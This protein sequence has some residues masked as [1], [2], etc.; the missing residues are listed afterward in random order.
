MMMVAIY[1]KT[2]KPW[3]FGLHQCSYARVWTQEEKRLFQEI[4]RRLSDSLSSFLILHNLKESE[5]RYRLI[6]EN[7]ADTIA[8]YDLNLNPTY[9]SPS[10]QKLRGYTVQEAMIQSLNQ[11][12]TPESL[13]KVEKAFAN[14]IALETKGNSDPSRAI[15]LELEEYC[16]DGSTIL[17][18][19]AASFIR[20]DNLKA[21]GILTVTRDITERKKAEEAIFEGQKVFRT[22][23]ENSPDIIARY[24]RNCKRTYV[25]PVYLKVA[26]IQQE[27]LIS[28]SPI[29]VSPLPS[30]SALVLQNLLRKV[31]DS[32]IAEAVDL[33]WPKSDN[34]DY[35]YN[36][37][38]F[39]EFNREGQVVS[40]MTI[41]RD[42]T[43]R[44]KAEQK[45]IQL[46]SIVEYSDDAIFSKSLDGIILSWNK[47][48]EN[49]Y[50]YTE[51]DILGKSISLLMSQESKDEMSYILKKIKDGEH[52][53][54]YET[55][56]Q[57]KDG[58][59]INVSLTISPLL[60]SNE[61][62]IGAST[63]I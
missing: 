30:D 16:K 49:I 10:I 17:I 46:A 36:V 6:A 25:N 63:K 43:E 1:P 11:V 44:K 54:H 18:E 20:D 37:Y 5:E 50:G 3:T 12:L 58:K 8:V 42:I 55:I 61:K 23:V 7:T 32:G 57:R 27:K 48:A 22:L 62:I 52:V 41:S 35:W 13:Q 47:G 40:V 33:I 51:T 15:L 60:D 21:T 28:T 38:A 14:Q 24:D 2:G 19:L 56:R 9:I 59:N 4:S 53:E 29:Q 34:I 31:F 45:I 26:K 39:P